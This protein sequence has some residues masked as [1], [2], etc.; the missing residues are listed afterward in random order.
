MQNRIFFPQSA[1]DEWIT[2]ESVEVRGEE[3][4]VVPEARRYR[5]AEAVRVVA[6]VTG[7]PD[8]NALV[9]KVKPRQA[10]DELGAEILEG[11]MIIGDNA[12]EV[13]P[14]WLGTPIGSLQEHLASPERVKAQAKRLD[15]AS[16]DDPTTDEEL[17]L[18]FARQV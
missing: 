14:G 12:Y 17:L 18:R 2:R 7:A 4:V 8:P 13:V 15:A 9:G 5:I 6:E 3:L 16:E 10:L 1:F 11:S